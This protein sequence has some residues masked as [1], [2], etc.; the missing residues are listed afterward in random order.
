MA[1]ALHRVLYFFVSYIIAAVISVNTKLKY[2]VCRVLGTPTED[3]WP[4]VSQLPE[5]KVAVHPPNLRIF[6]LTPIQ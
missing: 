5:F 6:V 4:G 1:I 2:F 3:T